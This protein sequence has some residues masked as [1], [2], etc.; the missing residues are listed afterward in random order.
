MTRIKFDQ[1]IA[2]CLAQKNNKNMTGE[3]NIHESEPDTFF[4]NSL[5]PLLKPV[6][7]EKRETAEGEVAKEIIGINNP[8]SFYEADMDKWLNT[9]FSQAIKD[10]EVEKKRIR[11]SGCYMP[12]GTANPNTTSIALKRK[13]SRG[14]LPSF[15]NVDFNIAGNSNDFYHLVKHARGPNNHAP[16]DLNFEANLRTW[17]NKG[18]LKQEKAFKY[19]ALP[20]KFD[21]VG[22]FKG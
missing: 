5:R 16:S 14:S 22:V 17:N 1:T 6:Q 9:K 11:N 15:T 7:K 3:D 13:G 12:F 10:R 21:S 8:P 20:D 18:S 2:E 4:R 19:P